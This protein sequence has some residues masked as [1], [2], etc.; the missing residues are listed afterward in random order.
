VQ[1]LIVEYDEKEHWK[2]TF[3]PV[4][5]VMPDKTKEG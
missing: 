2:I 4:G 5:Y 1:I 3:N